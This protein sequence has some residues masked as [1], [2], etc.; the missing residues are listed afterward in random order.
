MKRLADLVSR[1]LDDM[2]STRVLPSGALTAVASVPIFAELRNLLM[3]LSLG[4]Q[5][6]ALAAAEI[7][8]VFRLARATISKTSE[9]ARVLGCLTDAGLSVDDMVAL[10]ADLQGATERLSDLVVAMEKGTLTTGAFVSLDEVLRAGALLADHLIRNLGGLTITGKLDRPLR[11]ARPTAVMAVSGLLTLLARAIPVETG[12]S[13]VVVVVSEEDGFASVT[14]SA[15]FA[16]SETY[17]DV[18][19]RFSTLIGG[20]EHVLRVRN[21]GDKVTLLLGSR[22]Q[23]FRAT[24]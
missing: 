4:F 12:S 7:A 9:N 16:S 22:S 3:P 1:R 5:S 13:G 2:R 23:A 19:R 10:V 15:N 18:A 21:D 6:L 20:D 8:P 17:D 14:S 11:V 24:L